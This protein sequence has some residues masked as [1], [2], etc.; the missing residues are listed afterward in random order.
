MKILFTSLAVAAAVTFAPMAA[1]AQS[2]TARK[3]LRQQ[4]AALQGAKT[5]AQARRDC[6]R[7][8]R[9]SK[10]RKSALRT[11][12]KACIQQGMQGNS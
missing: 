11:K 3:V 4:P 1:Q 8:F 2:D 10:E 12:M 5:E 7:Q 6:Q 9:G